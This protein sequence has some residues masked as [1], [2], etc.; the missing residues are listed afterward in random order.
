MSDDSSAEDGP[1]MLD[2]AKLGGLVRAFLDCCHEGLT[3]RWDAWKLDATIGDVHEVLGALLSRQ[4]TLA[5]EI[6]RSPAMWNEHSAP[7]FLR[8]MCDTHINVAWILKDPVPRA[9][10]FILYG[11]GQVKL[12]LAHR[13]AH[14]ESS[15]SRAEEEIIVEGLESFLRSQRHEFLTVVNLGSWSGKSTR[16]MAEEA[17]C[18][19]FY[20][21]VYTPFS[22]VLHSQWQHVSRFNLEY[23][24]NP[25]HG[26]HRVPVLVL[27]AIEPDYLYLAAKYLQKTF[28]AF[29]Q[30][31]VTAPATSV[32]STAIRLLNE[33][34]GIESEE[35]PTRERE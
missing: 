15:M 20:N 4:V 7:I 6:A 18:I 14:L 28:E 23:C 8:A 1:A 13:R 35:M 33:A 5:C 21:L 17:D 27:P 32:L 22:G 29:D 3:T 26:L 16:V 2:P 30:K 9:R 19:D 10:E 24:T 31:Y 34:A 25:L 12:E 11:L